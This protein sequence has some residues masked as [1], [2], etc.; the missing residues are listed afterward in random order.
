MKIEYL[1]QKTRGGQEVN[2]MTKENITFFT[3]EDIDN[4]DVGSNL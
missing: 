3:K 2:E 4:I 1:K